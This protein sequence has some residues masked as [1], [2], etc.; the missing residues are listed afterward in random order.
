MEEKQLDRKTIIKNLK[1]IR[2]LKSITELAA[3]ERDYLFEDANKAYYS[4]YASGLS[5]RIERKNY[6]R[7]IT[8]VVH[9]GQVVSKVVKDKYFPIYADLKSAPTD[10]I[11]AVKSSINN[12]IHKAYEQIDAWSKELGAK[13][14]IKS[15]SDNNIC[16][17][18]ILKTDEQIIKMRIDFLT[19]VAK[20]KAKEKK[21]RAEQIAKQKLSYGENMAKGIGDKK[22]AL[23][24]IEALNKKFN[25]V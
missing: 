2:Y 16:G 23:S 7:I 3:E 6:G 21:D 22:M 20:Y 19:N 18:A 5:Y 25:L 13:E 8:K 24:I 11:Y 14:C 12:S 15:I 17:R 1:S 10:N 4:Y 9:W